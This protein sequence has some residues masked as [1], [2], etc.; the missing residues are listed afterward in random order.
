MYPLESNLQDFKLENYI[1]IKPVFNNKITINYIYYLI[2]IFLLA[3]CKN[4]NVIKFAEM[5][6]K[7]FRKWPYM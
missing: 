1:S 6:N 5:L 3:S 7:L 4:K 2:C